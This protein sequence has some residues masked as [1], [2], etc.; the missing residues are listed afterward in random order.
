MQPSYHVTVVLRRVTPKHSV[1]STLEILKYQKMKLE[2]QEHEV[3]IS[4]L[5]GATWI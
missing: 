3:D 1:S 2:Y 4:K 5:E